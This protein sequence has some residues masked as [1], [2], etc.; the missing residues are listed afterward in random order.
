MLLSAARLRLI[1]YAILTPILTPCLRHPSPATTSPCGGP[2]GGRR[3]P[4]EPSPTWMS[5]AYAKLTPSLRQP[6]AKNQRSQ[7]KTKS[8]VCLRQPYANPYALL[9]PAERRSMIFK[10]F[11]LLAVASLMFPLRGVY[12]N[13][14]LTCSLAHVHSHALALHVSGKQRFQVTRA[15]NV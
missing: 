14:H 13:A 1:A 7:A 4:I 9:T 10:S 12:C 15:K 2:G 6:Y 3:A 8:T 11:P 5:R